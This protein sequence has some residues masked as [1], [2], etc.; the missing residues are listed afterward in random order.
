MTHRRRVL[1]RLLAV[2]LLWYVGWYAGAV[3]RD[4]SA[5]LCHIAFVPFGDFPE[6]A[7]AELAQQYQHS[8]GV[9]IDLYPPIAIP[10][11]VIDYRRQQLVGERLIAHMKQEL[12]GPAEDPSV[13]LV[14]FTQGDMYIAR[15]NWRF[16]FAIRE[17]GRF[18]VISTARMDPVTFGLAP[19]EPMLRTRLRKMVSKQIGLYF[20]GL[21]ERQEKTSVLFSPILGVDDLDEVSADFDPIDR[22]RMANVHK[23]CQL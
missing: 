3:W 20:Y 2:P 8:L 12:P 19:D 5:T 15:M 14:G 6:T 23:S 4:H 11:S 18:A 9:Q 10:E 21:P 22:Q 17:S 16:A 7:L 1:L 13:M